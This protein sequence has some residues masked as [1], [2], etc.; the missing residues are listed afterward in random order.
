MIRPLGVD[1]AG[2]LLTIQRAAYVGE[3]MVYDQFLPPLRE[4]LEQ[5]VA[6][7][8]RT[9]WWCSARVKVRDWSARCA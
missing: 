3:S 6:V 7:L 8:A 1:D 9:T 5:V 2:E 4:T